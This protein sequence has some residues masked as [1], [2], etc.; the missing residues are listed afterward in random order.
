[1]AR[2]YKAGGFNIALAGVDFDDVDNLTPQ[3]IDF[4]SESLTSIELGVRGTAADG[5][6]TADVSVFSAVRDDQQIKVPLQLQRGDPASFLFVTANAED[7]VHRGLEASATF[8]A[9]ERLAISASLGLLDAEIE[10]FSLFPDIEGREPAHAPEHTFALGAQYSTPSGWWGRIDITGM[11]DFFF[12]YGHDQRSLSYTL[13]NLRVGR[14][15]GPLSVSIWARNV[16]DEEYFV[17]GFF[18]GN[19]PPDFPDALY[20]R[21]GDPRHAGVTFKYRW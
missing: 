6:L 4:G 17:R 2:G 16:L 20:T 13:T 9:T 21:L 10:E 19:E 11:D 15:W 12:D 18:F 3:E 7:G 1:L 14:E 8:A 5:R